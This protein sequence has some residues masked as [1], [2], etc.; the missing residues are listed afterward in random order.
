MQFVIF[1]T[2]AG[3]FF[4][5]FVYWMASSSARR[6]DFIKA[7]GKYQEVRIIKKH[8]SKVGTGSNTSFFYYIDIVPTKN[9]RQGKPIICSVGGFYDEFKVGQ[10]LKAWI[11]KGDACLDYGPNNANSVAFKMLITCIVFA[12]SFVVSIVIKIRK[13]PNKSGRAN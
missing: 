7:N 13:Y 11:Y 1:L 2:G 12:V 4:S 6:A 5:G 8:T 3:I 10:K 9:K